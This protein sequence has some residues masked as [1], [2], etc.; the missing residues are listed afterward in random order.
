M[1]T[2]GGSPPSLTWLEWNDAAFSTALEQDKPVFLYLSVPWSTSVHQFERDVLDDDTVRQILAASYVTVE[3]NALRMP[4]VFERYNQGG[5]P[6]ICLLSPEGDLLHGRS[7]AAPEQLRDT[8]QQVATYWADHKEEIR[9]RVKQVGTPSLPRFK[10]PGPEELTDPAPLEG[11]RHDAIAHYDVKFQGFGRAPKFP[12]PDLLLFLLADPDEEY[13]SLAYTTLETLRAS[14][15]HDM[16][17]GGFFRFASTEY[18]GQPHF[19]KL[20][21][22]NVSLLEAFAEAYRESSDERYLNVANGILVFLDA[23]LSAENGLL[24]AALDSDGL[25]GEPGSTYGWSRED[26][27][28]TLEEDEALVTAALTYFGI[29]PYSRIAGEA[30]RCYLEER[31]PPAQISMRLVRD[32]A[33]VQQLLV[34]AR[35]K[36]KA[37]RDSRPDPAVDTVAY[38]NDQARAMGALALASIVLNKPWALNRAFQIADTVWKDGRRSGGGIEHVIGE[39][40]DTVYLTDLAELILGYLELYRVAGRGV[41]LVRAVTLARET[42]DLLG[43]GEGVGCFD[44][45]E[46]DTEYGAVRFQYTPFEANSRLLHAFALL[47]AYT[48]NEAWHTRALNLSQGLATARLLH[49]L[50]DA[51]YGRALRTLV[52]PPAMV[53]LIGKNSAAL[54][55]RI[56]MEAPSGTLIRAFD[57]EQ[58]TP[59]TDPDK[60][61]RSGEDVAEAVVIAGGA[62][63][64]PLTDTGEILQQLNEQR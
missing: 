59:W 36:M 53:D 6:S 15:L 29:S 23:H 13:K 16:L 24:F 62:V 63:S 55:R 38:A 21:Y 58:K 34:T 14:S 11:I 9:E 30:N 42:V 45:L 47:S 31:V 54:R 56:L 37:E 57:P 43:D 10:L 39:S 18:W 60:Y 52:N 12:M 40:G 17:G 5:W 26:V 49:R 8:L 33:A 61:N 4:D 2:N 46:R 20:A 22:V 7:A 32:E 3:V 48:R 41:D 50:A 27:I 25:P 28:E 64:E 51:A 1:K 19:E 35:D 44:H